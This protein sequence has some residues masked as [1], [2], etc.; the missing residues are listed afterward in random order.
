MKFSLNLMNLDFLGDARL[1]ADLAVEAEDA[2]WDAVFLW[3]HINWPNAEVAG[4]RLGGFHVDP[5]IALG[6]IADRTSRALI[7]TAVTPLAR[8]RPTKLAREILTLHQLSG[9]RFVLG[10]GSG[11]WPSEFD[12]FGDAGDLAVRA[13][14]LD[15]GL[16][17]LEK[18]WSGSDFD[19]SGAHYRASGPT[20]CPGGADV[21]I[22]L[23]A[24]WPARKPFRRAARFDGVMAMRQ[25]VSGP[26]SVDEVREI[27][28]FVL[29]HRD[30][31]KS[32]ALAV[33]L[34][35]SGDDSR[36]RDRAQAYEAAGATWWQE[37]V[38]PPA[39]N[40]EALRARVRRGP[41]HF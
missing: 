37:G 10:A 20:F 33:A 17:L 16:E 7:G 31:D 18:T 29:K 25:D 9:G 11:G 26:L 27:D 1:L 35:T 23:G 34:N 30:R 39:E 13:A 32:F 15:E 5:W 36:D 41:P 14:M 21:P 24:M 19:H 40:L 8:R 3:D 6:L 38:Y 28:R 12:D 22:W 4:R 2:G